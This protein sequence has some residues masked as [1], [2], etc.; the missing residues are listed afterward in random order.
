MNP[1]NE[2]RWHYSSYQIKV[3]VQYQECGFGVDCY[4]FWIS[5]SN[6][7]TTDLFSPKHVILQLEY[8]SLIEFLTKMYNF[9]E[10]SYSNWNLWINTPKIDMNRDNYGFQ[11]MSV[12]RVW[13]NRLLVSLG[14]KKQQNML[15]LIHV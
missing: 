5:I 11:K 4:R 9:I 10:R 1:K 6:F 14:I 13:V 3:R 8:A 2:S 15:I 7:V 12:T